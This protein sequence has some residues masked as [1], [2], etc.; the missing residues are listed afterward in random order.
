MSAPVDTLVLPL[1]LEG[2]KGIASVAPRRAPK[3]H[4]CETVLNIGVF[5]DGTGN[6]QDW[7][8]EGEVETQLQRKKDSNVARLYRSYRDEQFEGF[9]RI[10]VPGVG[11]PFPQ[12]GEDKPKSL[13]AAFGAGGDGR[14]NF[15]LLGVINAIHS[16][17]SPSRRAYALD[18][19]IKALCRNGARPIVTGRGGVV[20]R[21]ALA[22][23]EDEAALRR[24]NMAEAGGLLLDELSGT[25]SRREAF[26]RRA[27]AD[28]QARMAEVKKPKV[29]EIFFDVYGF[30]RGAAEART[31]TNWLL[32]LFQGNTL[33][34]VPA[35]VRFMG[36]FDTVASVGLPAS[37]GLGQH[38]H[39]SWAQPDWLTVAGPDRV[40]NCV[41]FVAMHENRGSFPVELVRQNGALPSH[42]HEHM[43]PG[44]HS[45]VGGGYAPT[46]QGRGPR[47]RDDEKLSQIPLDAMYQASV[48]A[49]VPVD[50][51]L[52]RDG[53]YDPFKVSP[54]LVTAYT[55]FMRQRTNALPVREWL[56]PYLAWRYQVRHRYLQ[57]PWHQ[58]ASASDRDDLAGAN[59]LLVQHAEALR[60]HAEPV[61][62][63]FLPME[64]LQ[65]A[66]QRR[67]EARV[68]RMKAEAPS[69]HQ[70]L[71]SAP[72]TAEAD[73]TLFADY[74]HDSYAGFRP[75]D[76]VK[77]WGLDVVPGSW[78]P[79]GYLR[80]RRRYEGSDRQLVRVD[81][82]QTSPAAQPS[83]VAAA[84]QRHPEASLPLQP[85]RSEP[86]SS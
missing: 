3:P 5:F 31:F 40:K 55:A 60:L 77:L 37:F 15:A 14:I 63:P 86:V 11:T 79:E 75:F 57:L 81:P 45:D 58:R 59:A 74:C 21:G 68:S 12:I 35:Q 19:T 52:A 24:V 56:F 71:L 7:V 30:S 48:K 27:C 72:P 25:S 64:D 23:P 17:V 83:A 43:C 29:I 50:K 26:F 36:L 70:R 69:I 28:I 18:D 54:A 20:Q 76:K 44:M 2:V 49:Q 61:S 1:P 80:W 13:G 10:Y 67:A 78:E 46:E 38:G 42:C 47:G 22:A 73:A 82:A 8:E 6:N 16:T 85:S 51:A 53:A 84:P 41:H 66:E 4:E 9:F 62:R 33:C 39:R 32:S 65:A 34:G